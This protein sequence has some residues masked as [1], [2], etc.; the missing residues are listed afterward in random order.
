MINKFGPGK[1]YLNYG[2]KEEKLIGEIKGPDKYYFLLD[3][4]SVLPSSELPSTYRSG[5]F[6]LH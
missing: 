1:L 2:T 4:R 5:G 3:Y 6:V